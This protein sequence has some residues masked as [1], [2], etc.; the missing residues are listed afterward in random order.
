MP[1]PQQLTVPP[2]RHGISRG[3][4]QYP[5]SASAHWAP[6]SQHSSP[7]LRSGGHGFRTQ[8]AASGSQTQV[9][10]SFQQQMLK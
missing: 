2:P 5:R 4:Q 9:C 6:R 8:T 10:V 1:G 7:H 3:P